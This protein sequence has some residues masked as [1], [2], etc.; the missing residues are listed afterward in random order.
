M[1]PGEMIQRRMITI[2]S[3]L[4]NM[5]K[6]SIIETIITMKRATIGIKIDRNTKYFRIT[7]ITGGET[8]TMDG[9][10]KVTIENQSICLKN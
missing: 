8:I 1:M 3:C 2:I 10:M 6:D 4:S 9:E 7:G 5:I